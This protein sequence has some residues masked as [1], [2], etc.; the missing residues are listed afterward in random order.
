MLKKVI[1]W[2]LLFCGVM[3]IFNIIKKNL[4]KIR[5]IFELMK[6]LITVKYE[7]NKYQSNWTYA[8]LWEELLVETG[9]ENEILFIDITKE[10]EG[11]NNEKSKWSRLDIERFANKVSHLLH[12]TYKIGNDNINNSNNEEKDKD[13]NKNKDIT[14]GLMIFNCA[15][16]VG[17]WLGA[18]KL[19]IPTALVNCNITGD[20]LLHCLRKS[21]S[22]II[23]IEDE[24]INS[25]QIDIKL[26]NDNNIKVIKWSEFKLNI[27]NVIDI[28]NAPDKKY[29]INRTE[30]DAL[31]HIYT[32][33]TTGLPKPCI[34]SHTRYRMAA[35][36]FSIFGS[37][38]PGMV[39]YPG[40]LPLYHSAAGILCV[41]SI[42]KSGATMLIRKK[43][44][45]SSFTKD[46]IKYNVN[47]IQYI[48]EMAR[49]LVNTSS[50]DSNDDL[51]KLLN[52]KYAFGNGLAK[53]VWNDFKTKY[54]I[55]RIIEFYASTEGNISLFNSTG[56]I[57]A[58]GYMPPF[59]NFLYP[60]KLLQYNE[61]DPSQPKRN[62]NG[63]CL[64]V[65]SMQTGLAVNKL[66]SSS[67]FS[68]SNSNNGNDNTTER[69]FDGYAGL[70]K[71]QNE[72]KILTNVLVDNDRYFNSGDLL[73]HDNEGFYY[74][75]DRVGD[76]FRWKGENVSTT[77]VEAALDK[78]P[79]I[80]ESCVY[81]IQIP[82]YDGKVGMAT[83]IIANNIDDNK[84]SLDFNNYHNIIKNILPVYARPAFIR[85][86]TKIPT[87][88][89]HKHQK[90][91]LIKM[92]LEID[93]NDTTSINLGI[94]HINPTNGVA[95]L[96]SDAMRKQIHE[97]SF[98]I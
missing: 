55:N 64:L 58:L 23:I 18:S 39:V 7:G 76:T 15:E 19:G 21:N 72:K 78:I 66:S 51:Y 60:V 30:R 74:F 9:R 11:S 59:L 27:N 80:K 8:D 35:C 22:S 44:S 92:K 70:T 75:G 88:S 32:S 90:Q 86:A 54:N 87:T 40:G 33:G 38:C 20:A 83:I 29:R 28:V 37:F 63:N 85:F 84:N 12:Y 69:R 24:I 16:Y 36:I 34:I 48:G 17:V 93:E 6:I 98:K 14:L 97:G 43:F 46:C 96:L 95:T 47:A 50:N 53:D 61:D 68:S 26:L 81:G 82:G 73:Y 45:A 49:Y 31:L 1:S 94:Y 2:I 65:S 52:I 77:E 3:Y 67:S 62:I 41:S 42:I 57:G 10:Q 91:P 79:N 5:A 4:S 25:K 71:E 89:T 56:Q 13:K